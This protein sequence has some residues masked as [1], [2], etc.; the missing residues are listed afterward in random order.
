M[1]RLCKGRLSL[2]KSPEHDP[3]RHFRKRRHQNFGNTELDEAKVDSIGTT[4]NNKELKAS[5][6]EAF[7]TLFPRGPSF[8]NGQ[9]L[10]PRPVNKKHEF[11]FVI[12]IPR[13]R[14]KSLN[15]GLLTCTSATKMIVPP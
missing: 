11:H 5:V 12:L 10:N 15:T 1:K 2:K 7:L 9:L 3:R 14:E 6:P 4:K 8:N 13:P